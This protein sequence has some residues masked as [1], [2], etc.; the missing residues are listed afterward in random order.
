MR[1]D[2]YTTSSRS[3]KS[4]ISL[5]VV[6]NK[7]R[8]LA[9]STMPRPEEFLARALQG[10]STVRQVRLT[11]RT[12][13]QAHLPAYTPILLRISSAEGSAAGRPVGARWSLSVFP[14]FVIDLGCSSS[15]SLDG[16][17]LLQRSGRETEYWDHSL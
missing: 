15:E 10:S 9:P 2:F 3:P 4:L 17:A 6:I 12:P 13:H 14:S 11:A 16:L 8:N 1:I 5:L 7:T